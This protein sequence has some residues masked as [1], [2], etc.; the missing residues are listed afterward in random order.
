M[1]ISEYLKDE[2]NCLNDNKLLRLAQKYDDE[3][4]NNIY[5]SII[6]L[7]ED[8]PANTADEKY[9]LIMMFLYG[10]FEQSSNY[11]KIDD[12][13]N[14]DSFNCLYDNINIDIIIDG[15]LDTLNYSGLIDLDQLNDEERE[16]IE[17]SINDFMCFI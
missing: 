15:I 3:S 13:G 5:F 14:I 1:L 17:D 2:L 9:T 11:F 8:I 16:E 12:L 6:D 7:L 4:C 10:N